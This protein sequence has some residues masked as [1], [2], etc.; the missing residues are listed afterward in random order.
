MENSKHFK[1]AVHILAESLYL[2]DENYFYVAWDDDDIV[3][4]GKGQ[5]KRWQHVKSQRSSSVQLN[6][7]VNAGREL[8]VSVFPC[9]TD[10]R[11]VW[12]ESL[13]ISLLSESS[14]LVNL[15]HTDYGFSL[16][17]EEKDTLKELLDNLLPRLQKE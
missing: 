2:N 12:M 7:M 5:G 1:I 16:L 8:K 3:Y 6:S 10:S 15:R 14:G 13:L 9:Y 4:V 17:D 11:A